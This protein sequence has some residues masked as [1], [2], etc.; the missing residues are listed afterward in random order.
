MLY[1]ETSFYHVISRNSNTYINF[2]YFC[3]IVPYVGIQFAV[4]YLWY[5]LYNG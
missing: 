2:E 5:A 1:L 4:R 3:R